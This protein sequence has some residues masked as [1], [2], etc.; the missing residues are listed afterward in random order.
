[1]TRHGLSQT[2]LVKKSG[3]SQPVISR[4]IYNNASVLN[5][6]QLEALAL[7]MGEDPSEVLRRAELVLARRA[8]VSRPYPNLQHGYA[9]AASPDR[10][11][12]ADANEEDYL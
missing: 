6:N 3:V 10:G 8:A 2:E 5:T 4:T 11:P 9:L 12:T 7:A 1:M